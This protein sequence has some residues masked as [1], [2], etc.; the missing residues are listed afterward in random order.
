MPALNRAAVPGC[1]E[2][3]SVVMIIGEVA[4]RSNATDCK[5]VGPV[6]SKVRILPSPPT[7]ARFASYGWQASAAGFRGWLDGL[8]AARDVRLSGHARNKKK[9]EF[10]RRAC[11][12]NR[13]A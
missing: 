12:P 11:P 7:S 8:V 4:K 13:E 5:S 1:V 9:V 6:S 10:E 3:K 2:A